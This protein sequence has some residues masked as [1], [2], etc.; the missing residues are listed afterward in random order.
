MKARKFKNAAKEIV[1]ILG[2]VCDIIS[3]AAI[4]SAA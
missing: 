1:D 4:S 3:I 2:S